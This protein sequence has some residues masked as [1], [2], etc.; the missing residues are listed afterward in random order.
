MVIG[1]MGVYF[2]LFLSSYLDASRIKYVKAFIVIPVAYILA[3]SVAGY[4]YQ[5]GL[6]TLSIFVNVM[7]AFIQ[8]LIISTITASFGTRSTEDAMA[9][10]P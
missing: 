8:L 2:S 5:Q 3:F 10:K 9:L 4:F 1:T 6:D 7:V